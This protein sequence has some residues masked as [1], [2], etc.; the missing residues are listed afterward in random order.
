LTTENCLTLPKWGNE[1]VVFYD[2]VLV[3]LNYNDDDY[4]YILNKIATLWPHREQSVYIRM[5]RGTLLYNLI[6][7]HLKVPTLAL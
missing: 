5:I 2:C 3:W 6:Q 4:N 7:G 1:G